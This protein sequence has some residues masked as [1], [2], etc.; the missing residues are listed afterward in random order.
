MNLYNTDKE[1]LIDILEDEEERL[2]SYLSEELQEKHKYNFYR[3]I[4]VT[5]ML[6]KIKK[7]LKKMTRWIFSSSHF[8][9]I[10]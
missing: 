10:V 5:D 3:F 4:A 8:M 9:K 7:C 2:I 6:R 1:Y